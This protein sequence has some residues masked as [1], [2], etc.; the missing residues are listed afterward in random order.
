MATT[1]KA[2]IKAYKAENGLPV[3][4]PLYTYGAWLKQGYRVRKGEKCKHRVQMWKMGQK[5][6]DE[7]NMVNTGRCFHKT[8]YLFTSEQIE[9]ITAS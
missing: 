8:M 1:N 7:G 4:Y 3:N 6:D 2:I 9:K 5:K